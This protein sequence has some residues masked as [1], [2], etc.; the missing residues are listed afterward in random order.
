M[1]RQKITIL[2]KLT[3]L[4]LATLALAYLTLFGTAFHT[5]NASIFI[6]AALA[7]LCVANFTGQ[8]FL[9]GRRFTK[10]T[11]AVQGVSAL[12]LLSIFYVAVLMP[13]AGERIPDLTGV[14]YWDLATGSRI[15]YIKLEPEKTTHAEPIIFLHGG[16]GIADLHGDA[17]YFGRLREEGY[18]VY[19]YDQ[20]GTGRSSRLQDPS[21]YTIER[22]AADLESIRHQIGAEKVIL[23]GHSYG[24]S[25]AALYIA[26]HGEHVAKFIASSPGALLGGIAGGGDLLL[27][28]TTVQKLSIYA[29]ILQPRPLMTYLLLQ[30]NPRAAHQFAGDSEMDARNDDVYA[31]SESA[32]HCGSKE[33]THS[34]YGLGFYAFQFPQSAHTVR[35]KDFTPA[36]KHYKIP[37][38]VIK[39][40]CDYL[41]WASALD[42]LNAFQSGPAQ[43]VYLSGAGH[44]A[45]QDKPEEFEMNLKAFLN[46]QPLPNQYTGRSVPADYEKGN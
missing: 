12:I 17:A 3:M 25:L 6:G 32:L 9:L 7:M 16:P 2:T 35:P 27:R 14:Q 15:A 30:I 46:D 20:L 45:Y 19:V 10:R 43:L 34:L 8:Y 26:Q 39:G 5:D 22:N 4:G 18:V 31:A 29:Q 24:A 1:L 23:I 33:L 40:S 41:S 36:L 28:L 42:Y 13:T 21:G 38:L 11:I 37:T 44:N